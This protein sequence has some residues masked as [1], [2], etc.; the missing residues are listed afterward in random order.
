[1]RLVKQAITAVS[2]TNFF[3]LI[4]ARAVL[5]LILAAALKLLVAE[6]SSALTSP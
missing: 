2:Q 3:Q 6:A 1:M 4:A 5:V